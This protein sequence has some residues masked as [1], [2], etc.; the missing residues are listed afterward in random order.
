MFRA[1]D[2]SFLFDNTRKLF[3][4]GYR[5]TEGSLDPNCYDLL[6]SEARLTS[7]IA[8]AKGEVPPS[9]WFR[10]GRALTPVGR[11]SALISWS[12][13][14]FEYLMPALV[15]R[16]PA[17]SLL[18]QTYELVVHRQIEYGAERHVPWGD[19]GVGIQRARSRTSPTNTPALAC[20]D[21][22]SS[23]VSAKIS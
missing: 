3:S 5:A 1:M 6:A 20:P 4:I 16:S 18:S 8:I 7:F 13:S 15:M 19:V 12:G 23:A 2:F 11:G 14:M 17:T 9:H 10:L 21:W 22:G